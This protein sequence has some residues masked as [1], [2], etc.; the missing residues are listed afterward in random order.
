M[1]ERRIQGEIE[2]RMFQGKVILLLGPRQVGKT[3]IFKMILE[4]K[5]NVLWLNGDNPETIQLLSEITPA[6]WKLIIGDSKI[7]MIDEAQRI[8]DIGFKLKLLIDEI[9]DVQLIATGSSSFELSSEMNEPL[10]GRKWSYELLPFS[11]AEMV[12]ATDFVMERSRLN[13][14]LIFGYYPE[15]V[16]ADP[17]DR[18]DLLLQLSDSYLFKDILMWQEIKKPEKLTK[19]IQAISYQLGNEVSYHELGNLVGLDNETV[20]RYIHFLEQAFVIFRLPTFS[21]NLRK[22]LTKKRKI[23]FYDNGIRNAV[24]GQFQAVELRQDIG[25]LWE[26][27]LISE[28]NKYLSNHQIYGNRYFWRTHDQQEIDYIEERD[29]KLLAFEFKWNPKAKTKFSKTFTN[30]YPNHELA[31]VNRDNFELFL[32]LGSD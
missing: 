20:E 24:I 1:I 23:Y 6:K 4:N 13:E 27:F 7:V 12:S 5:K 22:E 26:N 14:R 15:I 9:K 18:L 28:R 31:V 17:K 19:L 21:R 3:T 25:A 32:G 2:R 11:F 10:T 29:G 8:P 30:A 16:Q